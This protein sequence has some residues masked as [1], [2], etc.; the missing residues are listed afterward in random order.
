MS[1]NPFLIPTVSSQRC[2]WCVTILFRPLVPNSWSKAG[3]HSL[4]TN[5][6]SGPAPGAGENPLEPYSCF[7]YLLGNLLKRLVFTVVLFC[8]QFS[9]WCYWILITIRLLD[10]LLSSWNGCGVSRSREVSDGRSHLEGAFQ[11][12]RKLPALLPQS[13]SAFSTQTSCGSP[14]PYTESSCLHPHLL[15]CLCP[16]QP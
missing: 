16:V 3:I 10:S 4:L 6:G 13:P 2:C 8:F 15:P 5:D 1:K 7:S 9:P 11:T 12:E 14:G